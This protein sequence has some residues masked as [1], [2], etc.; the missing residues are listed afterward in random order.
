MFSDIFSLFA[1]LAFVMGL[2]V[3]IIA[4]STGRLVSIIC[5]SENEGLTLV[6]IWSTFIVKDFLK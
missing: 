2:S 1:T 5:A 6:E 3:P 4:Q